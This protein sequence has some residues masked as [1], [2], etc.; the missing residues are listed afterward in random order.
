MDHSSTVLA[1]DTCIGEGSIALHA[2]GELLYGVTGLRGKDGAFQPLKVLD[3]VLSDNSLEFGEIDL[4]VVTRGPG[5]FTGVRTGLSLVKGFLQASRIKTAAVTVT[6][7]YVTAAPSECLRACAAIYAGRDEF[8]YQYFSR[9]D[10]ECLFRAEGPHKVGTVD[11]LSFLLESGRDRA[12]IA[13]PRLIKGTFGERASGMLEVR[14]A[15]ENVAA[16]AFGSLSSVDIDSED[17]EQLEPVY[18]REFEIRKAV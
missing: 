5:S 7:A 18:T 14:A 11:D 12:I 15:D 9:T 1:L 8:A 17:L 10:P 13:E 4:L 6:Q 3:R 16:L 2:D